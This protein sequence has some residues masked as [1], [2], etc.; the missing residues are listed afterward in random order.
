M[1]PYY[2]AR[3]GHPSM[4]TLDKNATAATAEPIHS[5]IRTSGGVLRLLYAALGFGEGLQ[6][7]AFAQCCRGK[8]S[9]RAILRSA[10]G[11]R[12]QIEVGE[13]RCMGRSSNR[14]A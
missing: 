13:A 8:A 12:G 3:D 9:P 2:P 6:I 7:S 5:T 11:S 1:M 14:R 10:P 4:F